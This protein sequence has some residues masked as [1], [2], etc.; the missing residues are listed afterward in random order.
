MAIKNILIIAMICYAVH[1][2][3]V[4]LNEATAKCPKWTC[5]TTAGDNCLVGKGKKTDGRTVTVN[6]CNT[7]KVCDYK[8]GDALLDTDVTETCK[9]P[10][11]PVAIPALPGEACTKNEDCQKIS[12]WDGTNYVD[13]QECKEKVCVGNKKDDSCKMTD[14]CLVGLYCAGNPQTAGKCAAQLD[15]D[16]ACVANFDCLNHLLCFNSKCTDMLSQKV[17]TKVADKSACISGDTENGVCKNVIYDAEKTPS[18]NISSGLVKCDFGSKCNYKSVT[19]EDGKTA[20]AFTQ[21]CVCSSNG[22]GQGYCPLALQDDGNSKL[23]SSIKDAYLARFK[24]T[25]LH[26]YHRGFE[27]ADTASNATD[28]CL[29]YYSFMNFYKSPTCATDVYGYDFSKCNL[30]SSGFIKVSVMIVMLVAAFIFN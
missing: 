7:G 18:A 3:I 5:G 19:S 8:D 25:K 4:F 26:S 10:T 28:R 21:D 27:T 14:S 13:K 11:T 22:D 29:L 20:T 15:K 12:F 16:A 9:A 23:S 24:N 2:D 6:P 1:S 17:G 30:L